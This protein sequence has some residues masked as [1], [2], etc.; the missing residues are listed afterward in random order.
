[1]DAL[2]R[3]KLSTVPLFTGIT[4]ICSH[5]LGYHIPSQP[6]LRPFLSIESLQDTI[7]EVNPLS[8]GHCST[9]PLYV[10]LPGKEGYLMLWSHTLK[11]VAIN[12]HLPL[13]VLY[14]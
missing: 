3:R 4:I 11:L 7:A 5:F 13:L 2:D 14:Q 1:M 8:L 6:L 10:P 12:L 9:L